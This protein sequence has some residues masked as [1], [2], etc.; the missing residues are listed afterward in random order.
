M[1]SARYTA[2]LI[3]TVLLGAARPAA[4]LEPI[5]HSD[6]SVT[7]RIEAPEAQ[8][9]QIELKVDDL[10]GQQPAEMKLGPEGVWTWTSPSLDPGFHYYFVLVDGYR[11][12]DSANPLFLGWQRPTNGVEI[13][14]PE[15]T[16]YLPRRVPR[17]DV[18]IHPYFSALTSQWREAY[19]YTPPGYDHPDQ[20]R[21]PVLYLQHG[22]GENQTS[23]MRQ[24]RA[25]TILDNLLAEGRCQEMIVV[26]DHG[27]AYSGESS[28]PSGQRRHNLFPRLLLEELIP[29]IESHY[30]VIA[31]REHRAIAGLSMGGGQ[32]LSIGLENLGKFG[33]IGC[34][35]GAVREVP[36]PADDSGRPLDMATINQRLKLLW[37]ACGTEDFVIDRSR[38]LHEQLD[39]M[40][41]EHSYITHAGTHEW[42]SWRRHLTLFVPQLF[43]P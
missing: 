4:A 25:N 3:V 11:C 39:Q 36:L 31:D 38:A 32:A 6:R 26:M 21:Y 27:Y 14:D 30:R 9:V 5:I 20:R 28:D 42:Q 35:S 29:E 41:I 22:A 8:R 24:G 34:F 15:L 12:A 2:A 19:V 43:A 16:S 37:I 13:P 33:Y 10:R 1:T 17:G 23:W 40:G 7:F 18:R